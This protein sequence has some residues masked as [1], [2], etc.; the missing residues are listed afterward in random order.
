VESQNCL[1]IYISKHKATVVCLDSQGKDGKISGCFN[2]SIEDREQADMRT[3]AGLIAH[4]CN[5]R[6]L[7]FSE[8][9]V[10]MDST[11]LM[12][13]SVH[14]EFSDPR[15]ISATIRFDTEEALATDISE[16]ALAFEI[17]STDQTGSELTVFSAQ[18]KIL[19][20]TL[21]SLQQ[22]NFDPVTMEP[23]VNCLSRF[24]RCKTLSDESEQTGTLYG[25]LSQYNGYLIIP[26]ATNGDGTKKAS[27]VRT[28]LVGPKQNRSDLLAREILVTAALAEGAETIN[29]LKIFDSTGSVDCERLS[30]KLSMTSSATDLYE[31]DAI[32]ADC[33]DPVDFAIAYGAALAHSDKAHRANFRD[34]FNPYQGKKLKLQKMLKFA[35]VSATVLFVALGLYLHIQ[36]VNANRNSNSL[37]SKFVKD[38]SAVSLDKLSNDETLKDAVRNL[39]KLRR[40][41]EAEKKGLITD[42]KSIS[43][44]LTLV[45]AAFNKCAAKTNLNIDTITI[46]SRDISIIGDTSSRQNTTKFFEEIGNSGL[47]IVQERYGLKG[48]RDTFSIKVEPK[49]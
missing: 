47:E 20:E 2:V 21:T 25:I 30:E 48:N 43:S 39:S 19:S 3:L 34:D 12:Q 15:Q 24:M 27:I 13:H 45:L 26:P 23:D 4:G 9:A 6:K 22:Y 44:K 14:S 5:K 40:R 7:K 8:V 18:R 33:A 36:L 46:T 32:T 49:K 10:A 37:R 11:M 17:T 41:I 31:A 1:G 38:Y 16:V 42:E 28:F 35:A 29:S